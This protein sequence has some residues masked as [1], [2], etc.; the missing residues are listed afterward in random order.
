MLRLWLKFPSAA[1]QMTKQEKGIKVKSDSLESLMCWQN[2]NF[3]CLVS[4]GDPIFKR[5]LL[6]SVKK[7]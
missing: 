5:V 3:H 1:Q 4:F 6:C 2:I 7:K